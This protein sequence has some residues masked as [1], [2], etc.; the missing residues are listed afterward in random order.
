MRQVDP[1]HCELFCFQNAS[2][3]HDGKSSPAISALK[4]GPEDPSE[5]TWLTVFLTNI[6]NVVQFRRWKCLASLS[7]ISI[8]FLLSSPSTRDLSFLYIYVHIPVS[9]SSK[10]NPIGKKNPS[11]HPSPNHPQPTNDKSAEVKCKEPGAN[12]SSSRF[13]TYRRQSLTIPNTERKNLPPLLLGGT[14]GFENFLMFHRVSDGRVGWVLPDVLCGCWCWVVWVLLFFF[15]WVVDCWVWVWCSKKN[16]VFGRKRLKK[17]QN[18]L[19]FSS[20]RN[21]E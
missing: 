4:G 12:I 3:L 7:I 5:Q 6:S 11:H 9:F 2:L 8:S 13:K 14:F 19:E 10:K 16:S 20:W 15:G 1:N 21:N 18:H 17:G